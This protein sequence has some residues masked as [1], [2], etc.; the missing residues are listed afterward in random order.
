MNKIERD[1]ARER[2]REE[3][4]INFAPRQLCAYCA[5]YDDIVQQLDEP[6]VATNRK[7]HKC[8]TVRTRTSHAYTDERGRRRR[9]FYNFLSAHKWKFKI[10]SVVICTLA[11]AYRRERR[12][13]TKCA[14]VCNLFVQQNVVHRSRVHT[15]QLLYKLMSRWACSV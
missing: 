10:N 5:I 14:N 7:V 1:E 8:S 3:R 6:G 2:K 13:R 9:C 15:F 11:G 4:A 12:R